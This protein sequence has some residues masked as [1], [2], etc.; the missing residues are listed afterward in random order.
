MK[1]SSS[2]W[3]SSRRLTLLPSRHNKIRREQIRLHRAGY[4]SKKMGESTNI[5]IMTMTTM[6]TT[7][8]M[9]TASRTLRTLLTQW[10]RSWWT[11]MRSQMSSRAWLPTPLCKHNSIPT[12]L[13]CW[14]TLINCQGFPVCWQVFQLRRWWEVRCLPALISLLKWWWV[15]LT[16][17]HTFLNRTWYSRSMTQR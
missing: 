13:A 1:M 5:M 11:L 7:T 8:M 3:R 9:S 16:P 2:S 17:G 4:N 12:N 15:H 14:W 10:S 6:M